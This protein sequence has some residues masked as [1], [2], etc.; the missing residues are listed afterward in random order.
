MSDQRQTHACR[1]TPLTDAE[2]VSMAMAENRVGERA[3]SDAPSGMPVIDLLRGLAVIGMILVAYA[4][5]WNH[6]FKV[7]THAD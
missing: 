5:D 6:R 3:A 7:L 1:D 2:A 4:D